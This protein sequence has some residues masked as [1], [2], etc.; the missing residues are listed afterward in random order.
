MS[1]DNCR[2][3]NVIHLNR[4][5]CAFSM[6]NLFFFPPRTLLLGVVNGWWYRSGSRFAEPYD[7][8]GS[9]RTN[10]N[11]DGMAASRILRMYLDGEINGRVGSGPP[12]D[13]SSLMR[14]LFITCAKWKW[15]I[16]C[17]CL[18]HAPSASAIS[19]HRDNSVANEVAIPQYSTLISSKTQNTHVRSTLKS[20]AKEG[21]GTLDTRF[22]KAGQPSVTWPAVI[23]LHNVPTTNAKQ[24]TNCTKHINLHHPPTL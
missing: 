15:K 3:K 8:R 7:V 9:G 24:C 21:M 12:P 19:L 22:Y 14:R 13:V 10:S 20:H 4:S 1:I 23:T 2:S 16:Y 18:V 11:K 17:S 6:A 5:L